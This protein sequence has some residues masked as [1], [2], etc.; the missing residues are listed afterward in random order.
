MTDLG[1]GTQGIS[2]KQTI[3]NYRTSTD[4]LTRKV[5]RSSW[6][7][8]YATDTFN[9]QKRA[10]TEFRAVNNLGDFLG[11]KN[12]FCGGPNPIQPDNVSWRSRIGSVIQNCDGKGVPSSSA[13][14]K[15]VSDSSAYTTY[16]KQRVSNQLYNDASN[17]GDKS[18]GSYVALMAVRR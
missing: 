11:R 17:G 3:N 9:G 8:S 10:V 16:R 12:Y 4:A 7:S 15:F 18:H 14:N 5:L 2:P 1:G 6:N 13:N